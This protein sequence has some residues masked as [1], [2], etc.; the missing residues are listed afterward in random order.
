MNTTTTA[1]TIDKLFYK[2]T[3]LNGYEGIATATIALAIDDLREGD[4][5]P[6]LLAF[7]HGPMFDLTMEV[8]DIDPEQARQEIGV[9]QAV[10]AQIA[11]EV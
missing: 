9:K 4:T 11:L 8:F 5:D 1:T 7:F 2:R 3:G 10:R 6:D